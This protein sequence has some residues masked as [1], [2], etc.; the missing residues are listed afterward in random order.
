[1]F[2][3]FFFVFLC[4]LSRKHTVQ[5]GKNT[6][7]KIR[8]FDTFCY[9]CTMWHSRCFLCGFMLVCWSLCMIVWENILPTSVYSFGAFCRLQKQWKSRTKKQ[10]IL[11][12]AF[13]VHFLAFFIDFAT[14]KTISFVNCY[15][16]QHLHSVFECFMLFCG[17]ICFM[18][19]C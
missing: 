15:I 11:D 8:V 12:I 16:S 5:N 7:A 4:F 18:V 9:F 17:L 1:L 6:Y 10:Q 2:R 19:H 3:S 13:L 14:E